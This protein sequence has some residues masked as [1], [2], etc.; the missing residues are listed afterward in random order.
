MLSESHDLFLD[1]VSSHVN[2]EDVDTSI[3]SLAGKG[4]TPVKG[5]CWLSA[6]K[7]RR[8]QI[9]GHQVILVQGYSSPA[10]QSHGEGRKESVLKRTGYKVLAVY[11]KYWKHSGWTT[12]HHLPMHPVNHLIN[13]CHG[14]PDSLQFSHIHQ[15]LGNWVWHRTGRDWLIRAWRSVSQLRLPQQTSDQT[16]YCP[17]LFP[18]CSSYSL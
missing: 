10:L 6:A 13:I 9:R 8:R 7:E 12:M 2:H 4:C 17:L 3:G 5:H 11:Q 18:L 15:R 1:T 14:K 16:L